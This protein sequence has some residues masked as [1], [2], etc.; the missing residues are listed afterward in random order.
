MFERYTE[1]ARRALF[2]ARVEVSAL[3]SITV[4]T[5]HLLLGI[6]SD[7]KGAL[8]A[9]LGA[10]SMT[11]AD[12]RLQF[13]LVSSERRRST[14]EEVAFSEDAKRVLNRAAVE[15]DQFRH[16]YIGS[17]HL[18]IAILH[19]ETSKGGAIARSH[20]LTAEAARSDLRR[21]LHQPDDAAPLPVPPLPPLP[22]PGGNDVH[23]TRTG[24]LVFLAGKGAAGTS[25][26]VGRDLSVEQAYQIARATGLMLLS[27]LQAELGS[28]DRVVRIV[29]VS[30]FVN[31]TPEFGD[32]PKVIDGCS[33]LFVE[34]FGD[35][36]RHA[37]SAIGVAS[38]PGQIPVEIE[39]VVEV[40]P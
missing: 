6:L 38:L 7:P 12:V 21:F 8:R 30:G 39:A 27:A 2:F 10:Y 36:G 33:D 26:K 22:A 15:A 20:G 4:D 1:Q 9:I 40:R 18:L 13:E 17:E 16:P 28:L 29:K 11:Y 37:R 3:G 32:H 35:R 23:A 24:T 19:D 25:G 5:T 31:A 34:V 14:S